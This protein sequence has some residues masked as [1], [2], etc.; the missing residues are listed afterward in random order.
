[1]LNIS[2]NNLSEALQ[3]NKGLGGNVTGLQPCLVGRPISK[4]GHK[5]TFLIILTFS[6][7]LSLVSMFLKKEAPRTDQ[8]HNMHEEK[9][10]LIT[11]FDGR[12]MVLTEIRH[13]NVVKLHGFCLHAQFSILIYKYLERGSLA[14]ILSNDGGA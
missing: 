7:T 10:F 13:Q 4:G 5:I 1:M 3:G 6:G 2:D 11:I 12:A 8:T 14:T 9:V